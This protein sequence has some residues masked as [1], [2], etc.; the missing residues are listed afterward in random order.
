MGHDHAH[1][2]DAG[3]FKFCT[4]RE[5]CF[6]E[7]H[8]FL[9]A[10]LAGFLFAYLQ[11]QIAVKLAGSRGAQGDA[12]H[13]FSDAAF[14]FVSALL[15]VFKHYN[16]KR[17]HA[18]ETLGVVINS[19]FL[20]VAGGYVLYRL[21]AGH[22]FPVFS[23]LWMAIAGLVGLA[24]N[25]GQL[26]ILHLFGSEEEGVSIH[27]TTWQHVWYDMLYSAAVI[28]G[29]A[30][31]WTPWEREIDFLIALGLGAAMIV[32]GWNNLHTLFGK[33]DHAHHH[34]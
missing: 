33:H 26:Y 5:H 13:M 11:W 20:F 16:K 8:K 29:S 19:L 17:A 25:A 28:A 24:G 22:E 14:V 18:T 4:N 6:C 1:S 31:T 10:T 2:H 3:H 34:E 32:S 15:A 27:S 9:L 12:A 23:G 21:Y 7:V 30:L